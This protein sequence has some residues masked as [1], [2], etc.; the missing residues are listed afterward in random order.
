MTRFE[1]LFSQVLKEQS[2][3]P[4]PAAPPTKPGT[5]PPTRP[6]RPKKPVPPRPPGIP[7]HVPRTKPLAL[8]ENE[9]HPLVKAFKAKRERFFKD[10]VKQH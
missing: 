2:P 8:E 4:A 7:K 1:K 9:E 3:A 6:F 5:E 10:K